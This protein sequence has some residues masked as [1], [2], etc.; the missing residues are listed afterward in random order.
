MKKTLAFILMTALLGCASQTPSEND[1][2]VENDLVIPKELAAEP[3]PD[4]IPMPP[5]PCA[6]GEAY[7]YWQVNEHSPVQGGCFKIDSPQYKARIKQGA[8]ICCTWGQELCRR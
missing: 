1:A 4:P 8:T 3:L 5:C 2:I 7:L 6:K